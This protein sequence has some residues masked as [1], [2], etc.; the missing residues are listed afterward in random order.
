[1][2]K[3]LYALLL[4]LC[5]TLS[6][7]ACGSTPAPA[8]SSETPQ[9]AAEAPAAE[10]PAAETPAAEPAATEEPESAAPETEEPAAEEPQ[11]EAPA[12]EGIRG[13]Q[14]E[15]GYENALLN[16]RIEL[17]N[18][19]IFYNDE[20][21]AQINNVTA[22]L[23]SG[24]D[25]ADLISRNGQLMDMIMADGSGNSLN[26]LFQPNQETLAPLT[27]EQIFT[28][29]ESTFRAQ[30]SSA[31]MEVST[32][33]PVTMQVGRQDRTVLHIA[34]TANGM[35]MDEYQIWFRDDGDYMGVLTVSL[36]AGGDVQPILDGI[37]ALN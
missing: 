31:G 10:A 12:Q 29:G 28:L 36:M 27:D 25:A 22:E 14:L 37:T 15:D 3:K 18:G 21:I 5:L 1:M 16:L 33:E 8:T 2:M 9:P 19:W 7:A 32:F 13:V 24:S 30:F 17:P 4:A 6:L 34:L 35:D 20:Q 23:L 11:A 26:L